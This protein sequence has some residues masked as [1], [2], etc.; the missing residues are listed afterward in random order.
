MTAFLNITLKN[1]LSLSLRQLTGVVTHFIFAFFALTFIIGWPQY[2]SPA[3][4]EGSAL[5]RAFYYSLWILILIV[6][7]AN[8]AQ[9]R[10]IRVATFPILAFFAFVLVLSVVVT[11]VSLSGEKNVTINLVISTAAIFCIVVLYSVVGSEDASV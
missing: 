8:F 5:W 1:L 9:F 10:E 4:L 11:L 3:I 7:A 2:F 6:T